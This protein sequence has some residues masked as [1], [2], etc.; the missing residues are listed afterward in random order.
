MNSSGVD[1]RALR[2]DGKWPATRVRD[3]PLTNDSGY[4]FVVGPCGRRSIYRLPKSFSWFITIDNVHLSLVTKERKFDPFGQL[5]ARPARRPAGASAMSY[6]PMKSSIAIAALTLT[7]SFIA[8]TSSMVGCGENGGGGYD[9]GPYHCCDPNQGTSCCSD[10]RKGF[11][12]AYGGTFG[13]CRGPGEEGDSKIIC[14]KCCD[15]LQA[16]SS[17]LVQS[18]AS[19]AGSADGCG[20]SGAPPGTFVC[21]ACGD[22]ECGAGENRCNCPA[23]CH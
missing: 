4:S 11:C 16:V 3:V 6:M 14:S 7:V 5:F 19:D 17:L 18:T 13:A 20:L 12:F 2:G 15:G 10:Y 1:Q 23:D 22:G 21:I 8:V 9:Q